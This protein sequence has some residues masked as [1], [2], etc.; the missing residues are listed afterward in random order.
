MNFATSVRPCRLVALASLVCSLTAAAV[1]QDAAPAQ[2]ATPP[3]PSAPVYVAMTTNKGVIVLELNAEKAP[4][5]VA[6]FVAYAKSGFYDGTVFHRVIKGFMVQGG[7]FTADLK[8]KTPNPP[9]K[10]EWRNGLPNARG[11]IAMA[12]TSV[13]DS[14]TSQFF[15]NT[16][17]NRMLDQPRDGAAY[18]VFGKVVKGMEVVDAIAG[19]PTGISAGMRDVPTTSVTIE[20]VEIL[21]KKPDIDEAPKA[22]ATGEPAPA[23]PASSKG[24]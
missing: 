22:P 12:R 14:A 3:A 4:L 10:N 6:N 11:T 18:A 2:P 7:G 5:S 19:T 9:I 21:S 16:V 1:A 13:A 24:S 8:Q 17:D 15:I 20:K 23:T